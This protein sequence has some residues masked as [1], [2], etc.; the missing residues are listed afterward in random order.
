MVHCDEHRRIIQ[1]SI[2]T[3]W[4]KQQLLLSV[5]FFAESNQNLRATDIFPRKYYV[6]RNS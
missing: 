1:D 4:N 3:I 5:Y 2:A 6:S